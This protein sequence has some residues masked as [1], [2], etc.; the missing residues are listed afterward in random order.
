MKKLKLL[1]SLSVVLGLVGCSMG[2]D[3]LEKLCKK[4]A[5]TVIYKQVKAEGYYDEVCTSNCWKGMLAWGFK[6]VE[7]YNQTDSRKYLLD[8]GLWRIY[9]S[10]DNDPN[11][12]HKMTNSHNFGHIESGEC[13]ATKK[14]DKITARYKHSMTKSV[15]KL[16]NRSQSVI[17]RYVYQIVDRDS[18]EVTAER[19]EY[20]L[21]SKPGTTLDGG[22][23]VCKVYGENADISKGLL[24]DAFVKVK[25]KEGELK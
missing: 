14:I 15:I 1:I 19:V 16:D 25:R 17:G 5:G 7:M 22:P 12:N 10:S 20:I 13:L 18:E 2:H 21:D 6:F 24:K 11:C 8:E 23:Y 9:V 4:D 3:E